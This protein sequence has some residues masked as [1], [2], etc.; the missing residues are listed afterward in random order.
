MLHRHFYAPQHYLNIR[1]DTRSLRKIKMQF[2]LYQYPWEDVNSVLHLVSILL[3]GGAGSVGWGYSWKGW[4]RDCDRIVVNL[5]LQYSCEMMA[6]VMQ[7][8][9]RVGRDKMN[10]GNY[11]FFYI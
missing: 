11:F 3:R 8:L 9:D 1:Y 2:I 4:A 5:Q 6:S 10:L 7:T